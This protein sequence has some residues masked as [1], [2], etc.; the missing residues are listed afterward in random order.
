MGPYLGIDGIKGG[1]VGVYIDET[2]ALA[3]KTSTR[4][5]A[6]LGGPYVRAMIDIPIGLPETGYRR[7][8]VEAKKLVGSRVFLG[9]RWDVWSFATHKLAND[10]YWKNQDPGISIQVWSIREKLRE[11]NSMVT[12][13]RQQRVLETHPELIFWRLNSRRITEPKKT[14]EGRNQRISLLKPYGFE[15]L[16]TWVTKL[17]GTGI[18]PDDL[19]DACAGAVAARERGQRVRLME[20]ERDPRGLRME[21]WY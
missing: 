14:V 6:L 1:W 17:N 21:M 18:K 2:R 11:A 15:Q 20:P 16:E 12:P 10:Y 3:F 4:L 13:E 19:L 5:D 7:C 8:D 9:A